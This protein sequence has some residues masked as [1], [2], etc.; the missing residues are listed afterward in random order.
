MAQYMWWL[1]KVAQWPR[2]TDCVFGSPVAATSAYN[3]THLAGFLTKE[4]VTASKRLGINSKNEWWGSISSW[5]FDF[6]VSRALKPLKLTSTL[7]TSSEFSCS[8]KTVCEGTTLLHI[9]WFEKSHFERKQCS[10]CQS[11]RQ[12]PTM[13]SLRQKPRYLALT[14]GQFNNGHINDNNFPEEN[15]AFR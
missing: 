8:S 13:P 12:T 9:L 2:K 15:L 14:K 3:C 10:G 4:P 1:S 5:C 6:R 11:Y 7:T